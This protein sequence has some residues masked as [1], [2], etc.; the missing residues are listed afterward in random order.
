MLEQLTRPRRDAGAYTYRYEMHCHCNWCSACAHSSPQAMAQAYYQ[1]G[2]AGMVLTDHFLSGNSAIDRSLPWKDKVEAYWRA[3]EAARDWAQGRSRDFAVLFGLEHQYGGGKEVLTYGIDL[4]F[5]LA[6]P[7]LDQYSLAD[8]TDAV[9][10]AGGLI[11]MAHP[12]RHADYIDDTILPQPQYL[13]GA[14]GHSLVYVASLSGGGA[15]QV[16]P[17]GPSY[18]HGWSPD[19]KTLAYCA[20]RHGEFD[21]YTIPAAGGEETRLTD[22]PGLNDGPEYSPDGKHIWFNS[23]RS[24]LMQVWRMNADGSQQ[25]RITQDEESNCWFPH[26]SPDGKQVAYIAYKKGDV[27]PGDHPPCK[28]VEIRLMDPDG[29][30]TRV[31]VSLF[32]GQ[33]TLNVNSWSPD[34]TRLAFVSYQL[35]EG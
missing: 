32:G 8:Y 19:G 15:R 13:D 28:D 20:E 30:N 23:V 25:T 27:A 35:V 10:R 12:Y 18:L 9:R 24:G 4:D 3:Y 26:L 34:G 14:E 16:T 11:S 17:I 33:G 7:D 29:R 21:I 6:H 2:Y 5:L 22:A 1:A 31:L